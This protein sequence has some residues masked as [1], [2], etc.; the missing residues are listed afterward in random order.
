MTAKNATTT[1]KLQLIKHHTS[2]KPSSQIHSPKKWLR[3][4]RVCNFVASTPDRQ[5]IMS[6][7]DSIYLLQLAANSFATTHPV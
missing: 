4:D 7:I 1:S 6:N 5:M 2:L 3:N